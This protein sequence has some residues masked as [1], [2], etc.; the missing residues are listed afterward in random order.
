MASVCALAPQADSHFRFLDLSPELRN[1]IYRYCLT[2]S[3]VLAV[4]SG[5]SL[6]PPQRRWYILRAPPLTQP[7]LSTNLLATCKKIHDEATPILYGS[8]TFEVDSYE[9]GHPLFVSWTETIAASISLVRNVRVG[10]ITNRSVAV[11]NLRG[12]HAATSLQSLVVLGDFRLTFCTAS[13]IAKALLP[14][15]LRLHRCRK[16]TGLKGAF[17]VLDLSL[18]PEAVVEKVMAILKQRLKC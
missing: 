17:D 6:N 13:T 11:E 16:D 12:L 7:V 2:D 4:R 9:T 1:Q 8:N 5:A 3:E 15:M 14:L 18:L 10:G